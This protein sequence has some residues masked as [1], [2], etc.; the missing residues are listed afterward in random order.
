MLAFGERDHLRGNKS[1]ERNLDLIYSQNLK[2][3]IE[4]L[5]N[6]NFLIFKEMLRYFNVFGLKY[7]NKNIIAYNLD[8]LV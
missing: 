7:Y 8:I 4:I 2:K 6:F 3:G 1:L 5:Y